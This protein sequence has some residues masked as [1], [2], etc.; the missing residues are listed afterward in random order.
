M[1]ASVQPQLSQFA[2]DVAEGLSRAGQKKIPPRY[3]Y[4]DLG[5]ALFEAITQLPEY[6]LTRAEQRL[7]GLHARQIARQT[8]WVQ[9]VAELGSG[10]GRKTRHILKAL[11]GRK[12]RV[13]Y[14]PI[15][16]SAASA[17]ACERELGSIC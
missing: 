2:L 4:D 16:V 6:G 10:T 7:L 17:Q 11:G 3:F 14:Q 1:S 13:C 12:Q 8:G 9:S 15:D 5:S